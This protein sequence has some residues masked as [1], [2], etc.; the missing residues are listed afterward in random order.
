MRDGARIGAV[1]P[2]LDE[3][4]AIGRVVQEI[5]DWVDHVVVVDNGSR[6]GTGG[7]ARSAGATV[8]LEPDRGYGA[9]CRAGIAALERENVDVIVF[10]DGDGSDNPHDM[11]DIVDPIVRK[12][13]DFVVASRLSGQVEAG[14]LT[15]Q[16][17]FGNALATFLIRLVWGVRFT[18]LGPFRAL[19]ME[20]LQKL[21]LTD[22][23]Y[24]WTVEM[25][26][27]AIECGLAF[28]EVPAR[29]RKRIGRSKVSGTLRGTVLAGSKILYVIARHACSRGHNASASRHQNIAH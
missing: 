17:R 12:G 26:I 11:A 18:D 1:I 9:A 25:Q 24:G 4:R 5:P 19:R 14:A 21:A 3:A 22:R 27:R 29:Y 28:K 7:I 13:L 6:D 16:Q 2:A 20:S 8:I 23:D 15:P 10:L